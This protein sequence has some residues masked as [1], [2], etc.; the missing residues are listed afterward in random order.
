MAPQLAINGLLLDP[1]TWNRIGHAKPQ[2]T[3]WQFQNKAKSSWNEVLC[4]ESSTL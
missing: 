3:Q 1:V 2:V 4:F